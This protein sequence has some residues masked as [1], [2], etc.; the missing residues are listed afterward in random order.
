[1]NKMILITKLIWRSVDVGILFRMI[2]LNFRVYGLFV[3]KTI[4]PRDDANCGP[5]SE[6]CEISFDLVTCER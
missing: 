1:M 2:P 6:G 4:R 5:K 3:R